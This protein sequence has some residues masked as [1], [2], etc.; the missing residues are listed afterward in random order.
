M[1]VL[2]TPGQIRKISRSNQLVAQCLT[3]LKYEIKPGVTTLYLDR[4]AEEFALDHGAEPAFKGYLGYPNSICASKNSVII[5][6]IPDD[7]PLIDGDIISIDYGIKLDGYYGDSAFTTSVG[8][9]PEST[10]KFIEIGRKALFAGIEKAYP[11]NGIND[12]SKAIQQTAEKEGYSIIRKYVGHGIGKNLHEL[13]QVPNY[14]SGGAH[15]RGLILKPGLTIAIEPM[16]AQGSSQ[17]VLDHDGWTT[18]TED[19]RLAV[20]WEHTI[21]ITKNGPEILSLREDEL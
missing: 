18:R 19:G 16:I 15:Y 10:S 2:K 21:L 3:M 17:G 13:P 8:E 11:D 9:V 1:N 4:L 5:H 6:G 14:A 7:V 12:I 20:H